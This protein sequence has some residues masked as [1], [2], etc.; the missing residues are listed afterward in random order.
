MHQF[1]AP[2]HSNIFVLLYLLVF[3]FQ[4]N[5]QTSWHNYQ[6]SIMGTRVTV[7]IFS[8][9]QQANECSQR[10]FS[11]MNRIDDLMSP[12]IEQSELSYINKQAAVQAIEISQEMFDLIKR[13]FEFSELSQ[14]AFDITFSS[15]G[16]LYNYRQY[17]RPS[18]QDIK[19]YLGAVN[20]KS[21]VL[22]DV[23]H[24]I[25]FKHKNTKIDLG[26]I[27]KGYA[28]DN[29]IRILRLCNISNALVTAG[30]DSRILGDKNGRPWMMGI[31]HPRDKHKVV[32]SIPL[33]NT[34]ISTSGDYERYFI[35]AGE[36]YHHIIDPFTGRS[37]HKSWS[38]SV[39]AKD[40]LTTDALSTTLFI[41]GAEQA[42]KLI[43]SMENTEAIIINARGKMF[44]SDGLMPPAPV[45]H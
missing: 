37:A 40:A 2:K 13:S 26:G 8:D 3:P 20:Y 29:A 42:L 36:R 44:Y 34:A 39:I 41:L 30:G 14:G 35:E 12:Y 43:N 1:E 27:A 7:E 10:V 22:D 18:D 31:Q 6:Q 38:V 21:V 33:A 9:I 19:Q 11:E 32:V 23:K 28:V 24:S 16:Y 4:T 5:A 45:S 15:I 17:K 25:F